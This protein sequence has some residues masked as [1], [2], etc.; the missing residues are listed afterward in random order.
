MP[1]KPTITGSVNDMIAQ[2]KTAELEA[3]F[4]D[5]YRIQHAHDHLV[6]VREAIK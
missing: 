1:D 4:Y 5:D 3:A 6:A 2:G